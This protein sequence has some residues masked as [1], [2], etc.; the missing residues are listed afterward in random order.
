[1]STNIPNTVSKIANEERMT[2]RLLCNRLF[3]EG[4]DEMG[5]MGEEVMHEAGMAVCL[6]CSEAMLVST[7]RL[8]S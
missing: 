1:M 5:L 6:R 4:L 2:Y 3:F 8:S 7:G